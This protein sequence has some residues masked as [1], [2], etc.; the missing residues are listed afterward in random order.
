MRSGRR[1]RRAARRWRRSAPR[2]RRPLRPRCVRRT[3]EAGKDQRRIKDDV[4]RD[5]LPIFID[6]AKEIIPLVSEGVRR[7]KAAPPDHRRS[8]SCSATCTR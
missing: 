5:L 4:D 1:R 7:W 3:F 6:E 2:R 8:P